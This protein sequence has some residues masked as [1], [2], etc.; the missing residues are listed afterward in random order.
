[1]YERKFGDPP[2][3]QDILNSLP[4]RD[5]PDRKRVPVRARIVWERDGE[6]WKGGHAIRLDVEGNA[7]FVEF[8]DS[9]KKFTGAWLHPDDVVWNGKPQ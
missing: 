5:R 3:R 2:A 7:I 4:A 9:R 1:M 8:L 6:E